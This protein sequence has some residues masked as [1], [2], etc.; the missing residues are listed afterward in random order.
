MLY[1]GRMNQTEQ[2]N[3]THQIFQFL[4]SQGARNDFLWKYPNECFTNFIGTLMLKNQ[5]IQITNNYLNNLSHILNSLQSRVEST[6]QKNC[7]KEV[8]SNNNS[9]NNKFNSNE[10]VSI[11]INYISC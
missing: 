6:G 9:S 10:M 3:F 1:A 2:E 8:C 5:Q 4:R 7:F 11:L